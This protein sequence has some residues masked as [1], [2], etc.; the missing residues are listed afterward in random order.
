M[1]DEDN[2]HDLDCRVAEEV[3]GWKPDKT[4]G[5][6][7]PDGGDFY[8]PNKMHGVEKILEFDTDRVKTKP[9][10]PSTDMN[11]AMEVV[12]KI[13]NRKPAVFSV[14]WTHGEENPWFAVFI[15]DGDDIS[16]WAIGEADTIAEA[17]CLAALEAVKL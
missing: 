3:M 10:S 8:P 17:I 15:F 12:E 2:A 4:N 9:W 14:E 16:S 13:I 5:F 6:G 1:I 11:A 7:Y